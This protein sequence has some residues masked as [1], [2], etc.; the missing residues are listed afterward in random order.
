MALRSVRRA[1]SAMVVYK[2]YCTQPGCR[3]PL[4]DYSSSLMCGNM[5][6]I[7]GDLFTTEMV[8]RWLNSCCSSLRPPKSRH[9]ATVVGMHTVWLSNHCN[10]RLE[11]SN[12]SSAC[13]QQHQLLLFNCLT[14]TFGTC[15]GTRTSPFCLLAPFCSSSSSSSSTSCCQLM[16][17]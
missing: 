8:C 1:W 17:I 10:L 15:S 5:C 3:A 4:N 9:A 11:M 16:R 7:V 6:T 12:N 13:N 2:L 14:L